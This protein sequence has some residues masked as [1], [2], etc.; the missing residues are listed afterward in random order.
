MLGSKRLLQLVHENRLVEDLSERELENPEG[1]G[2]DLRLG[3]I[4][5]IKDGDSFL[6]VTERFTPEVESIARIEDHKDII[7]KPGDYFLVKTIEKV[8]LPD[9]IAAIF[10]PRSTL[11][12]SGIALFTATANPGYRGELTFGLK[13]MGN[14]DFKI[15]LGTRFVHIVFFDTSEN[16]SA[17]RGQWQGGRVS[18]QG[19]SEIQV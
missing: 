14:N 9:N 7:I 13:N 2:F 4:F 11:Q 16:V 18:T 1:S 8:N 5:K 3:E 17:Y 19:E 6:G 15:E 12:R 10:R